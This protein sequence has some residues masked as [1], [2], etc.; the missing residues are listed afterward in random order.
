MNGNI[1]TVIVCKKK[2]RFTVYLEAI[3]GDLKVSQIR[4][5]DLQAVDSEGSE[6]VR[7]I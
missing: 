5:F 6:K 2:C 4:F 1:K 7:G 3:Q